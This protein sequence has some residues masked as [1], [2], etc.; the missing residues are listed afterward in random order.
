MQFHPE[1]DAGI[2]KLWEDD[3][4]SAFLGSGKISVLVEMTDAEKELQRIWK[5]VIQN[6]GELILHD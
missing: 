5:L 4:D 1:V 3:A 2:I 6:W